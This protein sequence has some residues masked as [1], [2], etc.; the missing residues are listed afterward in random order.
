MDLMDLGDKTEANLKAVNKTLDDF[1]CDTNKNMATK[2]DV[3]KLELKIPDM[4]SNH[5]ITS[6][7]GSDS[8]KGKM[9]PHAEFSGKCGDWKSFMSCLQ[10]HFIKYLKTYP[11]DT[12]CVNVKRIKKRGVFMNS[13]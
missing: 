1:H 8:D 2:T 12:C 5:S 10:F 13:V 3:E 4:E 6:V 9:I 7:S 11:T